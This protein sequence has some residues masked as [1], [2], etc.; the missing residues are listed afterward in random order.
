MSRP[1]TESIVW[2]A[3]LGAHLEASRQQ[4]G[5]RRSD[6]AAQLGVSE[7]T[8]RLWEKGAVQPSAER[9]A[10]LIALL[11][12][13]ATQWE[14]PPDPSNDLPPLACRLRYERQARGLS[15]AA[16]V[17]ILDVAQATY[18]GWETGRSTPGV[19]VFGVLADFLGIEERDVATL[20]AAP[21]VVDSTGWPPFGQFVGARRQELRLTRSALAGAAGVSTGTVVAWELG[22]RVPGSAH[23]P[24]LA[25]VLSVEVAALAAAL[26]GRS[27]RTALGELILARQRELGLRSADVAHLTGT[28]EATVSRWVNGRSKPVARN[29]VRLA[30]ALRISYLEITVV[31]QAT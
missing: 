13:E 8:I 17:K 20:C 9:L 23:L 26:P 21:F 14:S 27:A 3:R 16:V 7:E 24:R 10:R 30:D 19:H 2:S 28:T 22:Y 15:Q 4:A 12:L 5:R 25:E 1:V 18:A 11:S 6:I 31:V 29:L